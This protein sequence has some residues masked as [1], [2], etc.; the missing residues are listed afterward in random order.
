[1][2]FRNVNRDSDLTDFNQT[3][4]AVSLNNQSM[5]FGTI[6]Q[7][8]PVLKLNVPLSITSNKIFE[9]FM[10]ISKQTNFEIIEM[11]QS[12]ATA[13]NKE[14]FSITKM[15]LKCLPFQAVINNGSTT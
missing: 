15:L 5:Q 10:A 12:I 3:I 14:P 8:L 4:G 11:E 9:V 13:V 6:K 7:S 2:S 1:M